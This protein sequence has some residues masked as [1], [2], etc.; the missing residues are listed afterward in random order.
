MYG[1]LYSS[2]RQ[3]RGEQPQPSPHGKAASTEAAFLWANADDGIQSFDG[4]AKIDYIK[5]KVI[6]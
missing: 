5:I 2:K 4:Y 6:T 1:A 3:A